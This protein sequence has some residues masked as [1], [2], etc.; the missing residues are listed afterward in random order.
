MDGSLPQ[1]PARWPL[2]QSQLCAKIQGGT[3]WSFITKPECITPLLC[4][5]LFIHITSLHSTQFQGEVMTQECGQRGGRW[6][7]HWEPCPK[8][9]TT[10]IL[11]LQW[12]FFNSSLTNSLKDNMSDKFMSVWDDLFLYSLRNIDFL[13]DPFWKTRCSEYRKEYFI[14]ASRGLVSVYAGVRGMSQ[15]ANRVVMRVRRVRQ[16]LSRPM[17]LFCSDVSRQV[18]TSLYD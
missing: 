13:E 17:D 9:L 11:T 12:I 18:V 6:W 4:H 3:S 8:G 7:R 1:F 2:H 15:I 10:N 5:T 16:H 14:L